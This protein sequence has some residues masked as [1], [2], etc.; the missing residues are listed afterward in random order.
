MDKVYGE[1]IFKA[2]VEGHN[3]KYLS[4]L[5]RIKQEG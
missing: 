1:N 4:E 5:S 3:D 2:I